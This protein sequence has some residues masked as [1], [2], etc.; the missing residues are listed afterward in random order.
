MVLSS[1]IASDSFKVAEFFAG[2]G[3]A[4]LGLED[5]E[6]T[7]VWSNDYDPRKKRVF[8]AIHG[9]GHVYDERDVANIRGA[10]IP[11]IDLAWASFPCTDLSQAGLRAGIRGR[12][13]GAYW[14]FSRVL[15]EM[16]DR[17]PS[18]I[19]IENVGGFVSGN[20]GKDLSAVL[21]DL[22]ELG[23]QLDVIPLDA[24]MFV[25]QSRPRLF[26]VGAKS[27]PEPPVSAAESREASRLS[28]LL[29]YL[30]EKLVSYAPALPATQ[31]PETFSSLAARVEEDTQ[32]TWWDA[33]SVSAALK[34]LSPRQAARIASLRDSSVTSYRTGYRRMR[35]GVPTW[36]FRAD[37]RA[38]CLR[39]PK[40]G[41]SVQAVL[42]AGR[43]VVNIRWMGP[44]E[45]AELMGVNH[46]VTA[47][48][49]RSD[50]LWAFGD[51]VCVPVVSWLAREYLGPL[52][53]STASD[54]RGDVFLAAA[55]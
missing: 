28:G 19:A 53:A 7:V 17:A 39:T 38:G 3:L 23:Y 55:G 20:E 47:H 4:K 1:V 51:A 10:D 27:V 9:P 11:D 31:H 13:S 12:E 33:S 48:L 52:V 32:V 16:G 42:R 45:Y 43:G 26:I 40:G 5:G 54:F 2:V 15:K 24:A 6:F 37:E 44:A 41:S 22:K 29:P 50:Q 35:L 25:A 8:D 21:M 18:V 34:S 36:E 49:R 46:P 30:N 14:H